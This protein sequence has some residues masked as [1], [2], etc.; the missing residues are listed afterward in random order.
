MSLTPRAGAE[1]R[2]EA[3][4]LSTGLQFTLRAAIVTA[5]L[6]CGNEIRETMH[7]V[8]TTAAS[9][10]KPEKP[11]APSEAE[12]RAAIMARMETAVDGIIAACD[13][14]TLSK[15]STYAMSSEGV[16][17]RQLFTLATEKPAL[18]PHMIILAKA[19]QKDPAYLHEA[20]KLLKQ[21]LSNLPWND[22]RGYAASMIPSPAYSDP[23][24][25][26]YIKLVSLEFL[27]HE[28]ASRTESRSMVQSKGEVLTGSR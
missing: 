27:A 19:A 6:S 13:T 4:M 11:S 9:E 24:Q 7:N 5:I 22:P 2:N 8:G 1:N 16:R 25:K 12:E 3:S 10:A 18:R 20:V 21:K 28:H 14:E 15:V 26:S 17:G 23:D